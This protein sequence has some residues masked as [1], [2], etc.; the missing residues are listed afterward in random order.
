MIQ[1]LQK[2]FRPGRAK[3][4]LGICA[5]GGPLVNG[6]P[7]PLL[8]S[9]TM[10][11]A[12]G[13]CG[14]E[15]PTKELCGGTLPCGTLLLANGPCGTLLLANGPVLPIKELCGGKLPEPCGTVLPTNV[16]CGEVLPTNGPCESRLLC[17]TLLLTKELCGGML[18]ELC[19]TALP[20]NG[21]CRAE[22]PNKDDCGGVLPT[23]ENCGGA[24]P[25]KEFFG[26]E[27]PTCGGKLPLEVGGAFTP[28]MRVGGCG[29]TGVSKAASIG[30]GK[31][32]VWMESA[33]SF[34]TELGSRP[35]VGV[36]LTPPEV[37]KP[38]K[39]L[40]AFRPPLVL[41]ALFPLPMTL[42]LFAELTGTVFITP[43]P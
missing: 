30:N 27:L 15:L 25:T 3:G 20:I 6:V 23:K 29:S 37:L 36:L 35:V 18:P 12:N 2:L 1:D 22:L 24:L 11:L 33:G 16:P 42:R 10:L 8:P 7:K 13:P 28:G 41:G 32:N 19:G 17:G 9:G 21:P 5:C 38:P 14:A 34:L 26:G 40:P 31:V 4:C 39:G 43:P